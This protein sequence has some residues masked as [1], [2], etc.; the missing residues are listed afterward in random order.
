MSSTYVSS[1][2]AMEG[3]SD[4]LRRELIAHGVSVSVVEPGYVQ[5][6][7]FA[8]NQAAVATLMQEDDTSAKTRE[9]YPML[10]S[11]ASE[12]KR[13]ENIAHASSPAVTSEAIVHAI[14]SQFPQTRYAVATVGKMSAL[15]ATC[16]VW[17]LPDRVVDAL[18]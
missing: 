15:A 4:S 18:M 3:Y 13:R 5:S 6:S 1:K 12:Q 8:S 14:S 2:F 9:V 10:Y 7:I 11:E 16:L 17:A